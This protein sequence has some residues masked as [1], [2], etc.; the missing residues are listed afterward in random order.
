ME[1]QTK[2]Q[3]VTIMG[4][5]ESQMDIVEKSTKLM[6]KSWTIIEI[7]LSALLLLMTSTV[8]VLAVLYTTQRDKQ[9]SGSTD[10]V[11]MTAGCVAA[12][13]RLIQNMDASASPCEDFYK[14]AC[15]G[16]L[17][18]HIIPE[19]SSGYSIFDI[20]TFELEIV[21]KGV[22]ERP[23]DRD[24]DAYQKAKQ[25]YKSCVNDSLIARRDSEPLLNLLDAVGGWP[26]TTPDW[27][28]TQEPGWSLE[29]MLPQLT[30]NYSRRVIVDIFVCT[31]DRNSSRY[32]I[33]IDQP[34]LGMPSRDY[35]FRDGNFRRVREAYLQF[36]ISIA[37]LIR[38]DRNITKN[39]S[40]VEEEMMTV[41][42]LE[43]EMANATATPEERHDITQL[44]NKMTLAELQT[45]FD[46]HGFNWLQIIQGIMSSVDIEVHPEEEVVVY[47]IEYLQKLKQI[48]PKYSKST[49][50][51]YLVWRLVV[52][53]VTNL[54]R[55]FKDAQTSYVKALYGTTVEDA[56]WRECARYTNFNMRNAV[57][58]LYVRE[59]FNGD[60]K[61]MVKDL[62]DKIREVFIETLDELEWM[63]PVSKQKAQEKVMAIKEQIGYPDYIL[64][65]DNPR[66]D[67][68]YAHLNFS[69][70]KYFENNLEI[71]K[72]GAQKVL[73]KLREQMDQ[74]IWMIGAAIVNAF[75]SPNRNL[76]V[77]PAAIL[78]PPFFSK[79]QHQAL[80]FGGIGMV[81]AHEI[82]HGFDDN[83][84]NF[85]KDGNL[86]DWWSNF[87]ATHFKD[88]SRCIVN[89][90]GNYTWD[91]AGGQNVSGINTLSENIADNGGIR[92][93][94]KAYMKWVKRR[95][96]VK[97][98]GLNLTHKQ[99]FFLNFAQVWCGSYRPEYASQV[100]KTEVHTPLKFR[101]IG[102]LQNF[103]AFAEAFQCSRGNAMHPAK[104]CRV[105]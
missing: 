24:R 87:S 28:A 80:N 71:L 55:R 32:I 69:E 65:E 63:D 11:C 84:R 98:P 5:S 16:W 23:D 99:L 47:A 3:I 12:A 105:W 22:L 58:A 9:F 68:E 86:Y 44:Y 13:A 93:A 38:D 41:L 56:R 49:L 60:S 67:R 6:K 83:G 97:L 70:T 88:R 66:L 18:R 25:L 104:K 62:I 77:F 90:Y 36:M 7:A 14:Y 34:G 1:D 52:D 75:Y 81:I 30:T 20:V 43:C 21:L 61:K 40:F 94:Y 51:N 96:E 100:I 17:N 33:C 91:L 26:V 73:R 45:K 95:G 19:T 57:G 4:K 29:S 10:K 89:Q 72:A 85:D 82:I 37:K 48:L 54:S 15:G 78:Q 74:N 50:Q 102:S 8:V 27:D 53:H 79:H 39:D 42:E 59:A 31:D 46:L 76:I 101:V 92:Q 103:E 35:Y 2:F 64:E